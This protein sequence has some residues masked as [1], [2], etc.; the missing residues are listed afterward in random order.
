MPRVGFM[1]MAVLLFHSQAWGFTLNVVNGNGDAVPGF[2]YLVEEDNTSQ[3]TLPSD[4]VPARL[5]GVSLD[6]HKSHAPLAATGRSDSAAATIDVPA[7]KRYFVSVLPYV[8]HGNSGAPVAV[9]QAAVTVVV[10]ALPI[11]TAQISVLAFV[12]HS[13]INNVFDYGEVGLGGCSI[14]MSDAAGPL[15][16]DAFGNPLGTQYQF[17]TRRRRPGV[18]PRHRRQPDRSRCSATARSAR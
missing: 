1:L 10:D 8:G 13:P 12:D 16:A 7:D 9:G 15:S 5:D 11:P 2:R 3:P 4:G 6:I 17:T 14:Q 18:R